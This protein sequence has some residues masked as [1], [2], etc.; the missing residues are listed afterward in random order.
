MTVFWL[1]YFTDPTNVH[2]IVSFLSVECS[3][4]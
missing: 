4:G 1:H 2:E 3:L